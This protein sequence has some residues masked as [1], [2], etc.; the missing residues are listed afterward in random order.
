MLIRQGIVGDTFYMLLEGELH[1]FNDKGVDV[2]IARRGDCVGEGAL[3]ARCP[4][5]ATVVAKS[6]CRLMCWRCKRLERIATIDRKSASNLVVSQALLQLP[7]FCNLPPA[8]LS[9][10]ASIMQVE[11]YE[12]KT[13]VAEEG[14]MADRLFLLLEGAVNVYDGAPPP[15]DAINARGEGGDA[16]LIS[17][18]DASQTRPWVGE[19]SLWANKPPNASVARSRQVKVQGTSRST[20][21]C[22]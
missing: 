2:S 17:R 11:T 9:S 5:Q 10:L 16:P 18:Y 15:V 6:A 20:T 8:V 21:S 13:V 1:C 19:I 12:S 7:F 4:R 14:E 22:R 3:V